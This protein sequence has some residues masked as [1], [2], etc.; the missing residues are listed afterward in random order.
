MLL[1]F[2]YVAMS[3]ELA[4][5]SPSRTVTFKTFSGLRE[6]NPQ[7]AM[8]KLKRTARENLFNTLR[9]LRYNR[10]ND[11]M[12]YRFSSKIIPL[13]THPELEG[14]DYV[15]DVGDLLGQIGDLVR[16]GGMRVSFH[17]DHYTFINSPREEVF[18]AS[19]KDYCHHCRLLDA[20]GLGAEA[21]LVTHI[22]GGYG[23]KGKS[24]ELFLSN[25]RRVPD[26]AARRIVLENDDRTFT[27]GD[28]LYLSG[29]LGLPVVF[30]VHHFICNR[31]EGS[32]LEG[33]LP[34]FLASWDGSGLCPKVH[35]SSPRSGSDLRSHHDFVAAEDVYS[36]IKTAAGFSRDI[37]VMVEAK[38]KD[39]AMFRLVGDLSQ[40]PG[41]KRVGR[42]SLEVTG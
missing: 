36:F 8:D 6:R 38:K 34:G 30:D 15:E 12:I 42:A 33:I 41:L 26:Q 21:R 18:T 2:G 17:P 13:A 32:S 3:M 23:D 27:A 10:A 29:K 40:L 4:D 19:I 14:W 1:R 35:V 39:S 7:A 24:L 37:D 31:E 25:W 5:C 11:V 20:M 22:G 28:A 16:E 9:L